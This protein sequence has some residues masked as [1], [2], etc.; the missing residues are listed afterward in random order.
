M[1]SIDVHITKLPEFPKNSPEI[2]KVL[3]KIRFEI[4]RKSDD[5]SEFYWF[6]REY[7]R[8]FRYHVDNIEFRL[9]TLHELYEIH[10][11]D[12]L[13]QTETEDFKNCFEMTTSTKQSFQ[14]YWDFEALLNATNSALELIARI[15]GVAY[16]EQTPVSL[17]KI[18]AKKHL[19][20][21]VDHFRL[22]KIDWI[23]QM[24]DYR[25]CFVHFTPVDSRVYVTFYK[26]G[27]DWNIW[28]KIPINPN[29][30][31]AEGFEFN[32]EV[33]LLKYSIQTFNNLMALE[34]QIAKD[35]QIAYDKGEFP[36]KINNLFY[37]G[38]RTRK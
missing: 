21:L 3:D 29:I 38:Q 34:K 5:Y 32:Q 15:S 19:T 25:D 20:G 8:F 31:E 23:N 6:A 14:I 13:K 27:D 7:P 33:D 12:F 9:K 30:R 35:I 11:D 37:I 24:K 1:S 16:E 28:C 10:L 36:K 18:T 22:A 26:K 17:N 2:V 4:D